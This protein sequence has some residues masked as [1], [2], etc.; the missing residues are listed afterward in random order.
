M[1]SQRSRTHAQ[2]QNTCTQKTFY[3]QQPH[4]KLINKPQPQI[5]HPKHQIQL[6]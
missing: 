5:K 6:P 1:T 3:S 2:K 4:I